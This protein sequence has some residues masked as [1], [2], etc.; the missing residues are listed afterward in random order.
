MDAENS[1]INF[2]SSYKVLL[3]REKARFREAGGSGRTGGPALRDICCVQKIGFQILTSLKLP[4][5][6]NY[7]LK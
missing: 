1:Q 4:S 7:I 2:C 6:L 3:G 5:P